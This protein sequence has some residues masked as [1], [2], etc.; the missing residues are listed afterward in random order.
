ML[1]LALDPSLRETGVAVLD[2]ATARV[3]ATLALKTSARHPEQER[4]RVLYAGLAKLIKNWKPADLAMERP[5][6]GLNPNTALKL[7]GVRGMLLALANV[8]Q[9]PVSEYTTFQIKQAVTGN[10]TASKGQVLRRVARVTGL[11]LTNPNIADA[12]AVGLCHLWHLKGPPVCTGRQ[13]LA[14]GGKH[15]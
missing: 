10:R 7:G 2:Q 1:T 6:V 15:A 11:R 8:H 12:I 14:R 9:L 3:V 4:L 5:F 13:A